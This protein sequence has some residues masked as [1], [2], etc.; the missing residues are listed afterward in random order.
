MTNIETTF[1]ACPLR[2][3]VQLTYVYNSVNPDV[4][5][6]RNKLSDFDTTLRL[7]NSNA[8]L[9]MSTRVEPSQHLVCEMSVSYYCQ[10][11]I[12]F[13]CLHGYPQYRQVDK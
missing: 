3:R 1:Q 9:M 2:L 7:G 10:Q 6:N 4:R 11:R 5:Y 12:A 8:R 13:G